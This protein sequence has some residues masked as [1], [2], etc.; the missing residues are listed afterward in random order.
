MFIPASCIPAMACVFEAIKV[1]WQLGPADFRS[2][3]SLH[4]CDAHE[5]TSRRTAINPVRVDLN[6][7]TENATPR[8][9]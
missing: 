5:T 2:H 8:H 1:L 7:I 9:G 4:A 3:E 6:R